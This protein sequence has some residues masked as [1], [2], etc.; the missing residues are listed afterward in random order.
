MRG[1][2]IEIEMSFVAQ[3]FRETW[4]VAEGWDADESHAAARQLG[5]I[6]AGRRRGPCGC[7]HAMRG[8]CHA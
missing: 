2:C 6:E 8:L 3:I 5:S 4:D 1:H 7:S